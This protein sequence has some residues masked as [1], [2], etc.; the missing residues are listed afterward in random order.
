MQWYRKDLFRLNCL[1]YFNCTVQ[2]PLLCCNLCC[3]HACPWGSCNSCRRGCHCGIQKAFPAMPCLAPLCAHSFSPTIWRHV[4]PAQSAIF[5]SSPLSVSVFF[6]S[7]RDSWTLNKLYGM[8]SIFYCCLLTFVDI[9]Q[10]FACGR[11]LSPLAFRSRAV[12]W[13]LSVINAWLRTKLLW[14]IIFYII[15]HASTLGLCLF[16]YLFW[17]F[18]L[19]SCQ[20]ITHTP[21]GACTNKE[22]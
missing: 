21:C 9:C 22:L 6:C 11:D 4:R 7:A 20:F 18:A 13:Q 3:N 10:R 19:K 5:F 1:Q 8:W 14:Q 2:T 16:I 15:N 17:N 12:S